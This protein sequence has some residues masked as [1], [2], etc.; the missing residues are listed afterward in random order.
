MPVH[1]LFKASLSLAGLAAAVFG[2]SLVSGPVSAQPQAYDVP[3]VGEIVVH[4]GNTRDPYTGAPIDTVTESRV[5]YTDDLDLNT[6]WGQRVLLR[7]V[8]RAATDA[9][10]SLDMRYV[11]IDSDSPACYRDAVHDAMAQAEQMVGHPLYAWND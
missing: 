9:C 6:R 1:R 5:V 2:L 7:R 3:A 11:T 8:Q 10:D 4:P